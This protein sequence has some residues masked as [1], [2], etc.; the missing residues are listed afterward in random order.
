LYLL[1]ATTDLDRIENG[2]W[3]YF[4]FIFDVIFGKCLLPFDMHFAKKRAL[5]HPIGQYGTAF[6]FRDPGFDIFE[7]PH[8]INRAHI[9]IDLVFVQR[10]ANHAF[11]IDTDGLLLNSVISSDQNLTDDGAGLCRRGRRRW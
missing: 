5:T 10:L 6:V 3:M 9:A 1:N 11:D 7:E 2:P 8:V 4:E